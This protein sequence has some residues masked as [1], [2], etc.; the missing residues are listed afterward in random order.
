MI[1]IKTEHATGVLLD[2]LVANAEGRT[3]KR[4]PMNFADGSYWIWEETADGHRTCFAPTYLR[5]GPVPGLGRAR[6]D[7]YSPS[8][9]GAIAAPIMEIR[10]I[11]SYYS[12]DHKYWKC[13]INSTGTDKA[14]DLRVTAMGN[15]NLEAAMRARAILHYGPLAHVP[16]ELAVPDNL[17]SDE[18]PTDD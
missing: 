15:T 6:P 4:D 17:R 18:E 13:L 14:V 1:I 16:N 12:H 11:E 10:K 2:W 9:M 5:I 7:Y 8:T 3:V